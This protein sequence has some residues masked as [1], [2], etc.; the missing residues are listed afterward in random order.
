MKAYN[1]PNDELRIESDDGEE[2]IKI[3]SD[4]T[5]ITN[6]GDS[7]GS[8]LVADIGDVIPI[9]DSWGTKTV[10]VG[11]TYAT[12]EEALEALHKWESSA[13]PKIK[14]VAHS[15]DNEITYT[16]SKT[17][18]ITDGVGLF[19]CSVGFVAPSGAFLYTNV[20][21]NAFEDLYD[22]GHSIFVHFI[23]YIGVFT[24]D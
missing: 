12:G 1:T 15:G 11:E 23:Y 13:N 5:T 9:P 19:F 14:C 7:E 6:L 17:G 3:T 2:L 24:G 16:L 4:K 8:V 20:Y 10:A 22:E 21:A 18:Q